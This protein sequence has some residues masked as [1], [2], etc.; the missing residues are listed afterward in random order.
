MLRAEAWAEAH[1]DETRRFLGPE[2]NAS[3]YW[4]TAAYSENAHKRLRTDLS[5]VSVNALQDFTNF[6]HRRKF[7]PRTFDVCQYNR[8]I[9]VMLS[10]DEM[11]RRELLPLAV[12]CP[13]PPASH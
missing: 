11:F 4:V 3:E 9:Y 6:L 13:A 8:Y 5:D 2:V 7:I 10:I 1:P 12:A